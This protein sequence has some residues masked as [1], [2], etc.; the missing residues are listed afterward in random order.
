MAGFSVRPLVEISQKIRGWFRQALPGAVVSVW[1]NTFTVIG[2]VLALLTYEN[3]QRRAW[4]F[5][6]Q[7]ASTA[8]EVWLRRH[9]FELGLAPTPGAAAYG[10][11]RVPTRPGLVVP[12]GLGLVREDGLTYTVLALEAS[13]GNI[14]ILTVEA[15]LP[16][17]AGNLGVGERLTLS[18]DD[19]LPEGLGPVATVEAAED[20]TGL[21]AGADPEDLEA[22][23]ARVLDRKRNPPHG[24]NRADYRRWVREA[25]PNV[26][27]V[28][29]DSFRNDNRAV[30]VQF[31]VDD[32]PDGIPSAAQIARVQAYLD[33]DL[34]RP[35]TARV[36]VTA[37]I[38]VP[39][40]VTIK[41]LTPDTLEIRASIEAEIGAVFLDRAQ[42]GTPTADFV[43][44]ASWI[45]EAI[46][47]AVGEE[48]HDLL[49][50]ATDLVFTSGRLPVPGPIAYTD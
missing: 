49:D 32:G 12:A 42:P 30:W 8:E 28:F 10:R 25:L 50:P 14:V 1:A 31:T 5:R 46:S 36:F 9:G 23:R 45:G 6:Q 37:P 17:A 15:D 3:D 38:A 2:K 34:R 47:R 41:G 39:V 4:L 44:D 35:V 16:G 13:I 27:S 20:G 33:D 11:V 7:F 29:V 26:R 48:R 21:S 43:L 24:G 40:P 19:D 18:P 22:F